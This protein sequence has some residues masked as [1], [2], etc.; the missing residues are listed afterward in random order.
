MEQEEKTADSN[1][2]ND[3]VVQTKDNETVS[4][5]DKEQGT[6]D[7][8]NETATFS[9][10]N[11]TVTLTTIATPVDSSKDK[12]KENQDPNKEKVPAKSTKEYVT[13]SDA[14]V[15]STPHV[16]SRTE[17]KMKSNQY[18]LKIDERGFLW[19]VQIVTGLDYSY[20]GFKTTNTNLQRNLL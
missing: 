13:V 12:Y 3:T 10:K 11:D 7:K 1:K 5:S 9:Q 2:D 6:S 15:I 14:K 17:S 18:S 16:M 19:K 8:D 20:P 4:A